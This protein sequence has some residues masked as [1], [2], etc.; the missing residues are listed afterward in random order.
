M[1]IACHFEHA[2]PEPRSGDLTPRSEYDAG[3][4]AKRLKV[5]AATFQWARRTRL[6]PDPD[7]SSWQ[8]SRVA[9]EALDAD[10][11][12]AAMPSPPISGGA[13]TDRITD[14]LGTANV[15]GEKANV[16]AFGPAASAWRRL[17][18]RC[19]ALPARTTCSRG[20]VLDRV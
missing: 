6:I 12:P 19:S 9:V 13:A 18:S 16:T 7:M 8:W 3:Q 5:P 15:I 20:K 10:A 1:R 14:A 2:R 11:I 17:S 4:A